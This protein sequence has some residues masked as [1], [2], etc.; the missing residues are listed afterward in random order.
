MVIDLESLN[1]F[2]FYSIF[3]NIF[4]R[5]LMYFKHTDYVSGF[6]GTIFTPIYG[7]AVLLILFVHNRV[8]IENKFLKVGVEFL[9]YFVLLG[10][11][12]FCGGMLIEKVFNKVYWNYE[13]YRFNFGKYICLEVS[14]LWGVLS[15]IILYIINPLF[16]RLEKYIPKFITIGLSV[17]F[18]INLVVAVIDKIA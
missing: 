7:I 14:V 4:E 17:F 5:V 16:M 8:K 13:R 18:I 6:M 12:E 11:L 15:L 3:G 9:I 10:F 2:L 1:I